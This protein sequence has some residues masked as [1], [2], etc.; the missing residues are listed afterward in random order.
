MSSQRNTAPI[1]PLRW[2]NRAIMLLLS[3]LIGYILQPFIF[4]D[5]PTPPPPAAPKK[6]AKVIEAPKQEAPQP[7]DEPTFTNIPSKVTPKDTPPPVEEPIPDYDQGETSPFGD[8]KLLLVGAQADSTQARADDLKGIRI[9]IKSGNWYEYQSIL[10]E[11]LAQEGKKIRLSSGNNRFDPVWKEPHYYQALLRWKILS[12]F[13]HDSLKDSATTKE[14]AKLLKWLLQN[15]QAMEEILLTITEHDDAKSVIEQLAKLWIARPESPDLSKKYFNLALACA[16]VF[17]HPVEFTNES[18]DGRHINGFERYLWYVDKNEGGL[19]EADVHTASARDLTMVVCTPV[20]NEELEW[21]LRKYRSL[22]R[23]N[24]GGTFGEVEYLMERAVKGT[25]PYDSYILQEILDKG[26]ICADQSYFCVNTARAVGIPALTLTG[27]TSSGPHAWAAVKISKDEWSTEPGRIGGVSKGQGGNPQGGPAISEQD[28]WMWST[29]DYQNRN[30]LVSIHKLLWISDLYDTIHEKD[31]HKAAVLAAH[32]IG[33]SFPNVWLRVYEILKK[34]ELYTAKPE[35][36]ECLK[37]WQTFCNDIKRAFKDNPRM[38]N[39]AATIEET[40]LFPYAEVGDLRRQLARD[41]R[42]NQRDATEQ[43]DLLTTSLKR[44]ALLLLKRDKEKALVEI[45]QLYDRALRDY[46]GS[47]SGFQTMAEDYF[48]IV[49]DDEKFAK[50]AVQDIDLAFQ[51]VVESDSDDWFRAK[52]EIG[53]HEYIC[54]LYR[55]IGEEKRAASME[56]RL[57]RQKKRAERKAL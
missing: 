4:P 13:P 56:K 40:H 3:V 22:R 32:F 44:E 2:V 50:K 1:S 53:L 39:F 57:E 14:L 35:S 18:S 28:F 12:T 30:T 10:T 27:V 42:R 8:L 49:K 37:L 46:G 6:V 16:V 21:A 20:S 9:A 29:R 45:S 5:Q 19:L 34:D 23:K 38:G 25:N 17:D 36:P 43:A 41:R 26:G 48:E 52:T 51:R 24:W 33:K 47:V 55:K 7:K 54:Q 11:A 15:D 31:D